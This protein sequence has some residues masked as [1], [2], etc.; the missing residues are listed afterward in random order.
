MH[1]DGHI[2]VGNQKVM[3][4]VG[5]GTVDIVTMVNELKRK[6]TSYDGIY[7]PDLM[8]SPTSVSRPLKWNYKVMFDVDRQVK[9][10][11]R[12]ELIHKSTRDV[13][14]VGVETQDGVYELSLKICSGKK[15]VME[16]PNDKKRHERLGNCDWDTLRQSLPH[17]VRVDGKDI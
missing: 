9:G 10:A 15:H 16:R 7:V 6:I 4:S 17:I 14:L 5:F 2:L 1:A 8:Y 13:K 11:D 3:T 12:V